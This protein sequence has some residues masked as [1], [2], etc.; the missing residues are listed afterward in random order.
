MMT[1]TEYAKQVLQVRRDHED[2][3]RTSAEAADAESRLRADLDAA[4]RHAAMHPIEE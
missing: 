3:L 2:G 4:K 1:F